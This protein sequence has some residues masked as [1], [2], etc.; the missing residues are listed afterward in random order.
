MIC[1][2]HFL[3]QVIFLSPLLNPSSLETQKKK[4]ELPVTILHRDNTTY[5]N[6]F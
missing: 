3:W 5:K 2:V 4:P 1:V 6:G